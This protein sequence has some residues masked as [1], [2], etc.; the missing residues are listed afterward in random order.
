MAATLVVGI[1]PSGD[2]QYVKSM[3]AAAAVDPA[4]LKVL[5]SKPEYDE[6]PFS[7]V[8]VASLADRDLAH[9][10]TRGT[11]VLPDFG[12][13]TVPGLGGRVSL[14][15]F[16]HPRVRDYFADAAIPRGDA[17][18]YNDA[19]AGGRYVIVYSCGRDDAP[20]ARS[21]LEAA[22]VIDVRVY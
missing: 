6:S 22:G 2:A 16:S 21:A 7:F 14:A 11:G 18:G 4:N 19:I 3:I 13:T 9:A 5:T 17:E 20:G 10:M 12:G 15:A 8:R 1:V